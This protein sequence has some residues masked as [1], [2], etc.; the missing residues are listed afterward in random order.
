M[1]KEL[2][3][4]FKEKTSK[5]VVLVDFFAPWCGPCKQ[6]APILEGLDSELKSVSIYKV[7]IDDH[8][9]IATEF[10]VRSIPTLKLFKDGKEVSTKVGMLPKSSIE[11]WVDEHSG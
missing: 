3:K 11:K 4:D 5:G 7:N 1:V 9:E 6:I 10:Q 8:P 2:S